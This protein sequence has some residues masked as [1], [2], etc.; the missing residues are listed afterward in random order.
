MVNLN[1]YEK[2]QKKKI[3]FSVPVKKELDNSKTI[4]FKLKFIGS[5]RFMSTSVSSLVNNL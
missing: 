1:S 3:T 5:F 4:T 2:I